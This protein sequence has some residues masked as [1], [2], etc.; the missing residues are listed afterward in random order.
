[1]PTKHL[2]IAALVASGGC[3]RI[4]PTPPATPQ[5]EPVSASLPSGPPSTFVPTTADARLT[6]VIDI[7]DGMTKAA[8]F[9]AASDYLAEK[10]SIDVSDPRAG[11]LMT[12]WQNPV[13]GGAPDL[14]Y[15]TR[16]IVRVGEDGKQAS[17]RVEANWQHD[18]GWDI[19]YD[20]QVLED[21]LVAL[22]TRV[23]KRPG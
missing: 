5:P 9:R 18:D 17:V 21:A 12:T 7:R 2:L 22:L 19:G 1:M 14:R 20:T 6:R 15:R 11:F 16:L 4:R 23:G 3:A 13:R 10:F 8:V